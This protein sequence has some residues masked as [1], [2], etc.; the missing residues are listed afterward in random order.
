MRDFTRIKRIMGKLEEV[1]AHNPD[2]RLTQLLIYTGVAADS[3][4]WPMEDEWAEACIDKFG[5]KV[6]K[7]KK[8]GRL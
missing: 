8:E 1:W 3:A 2:M 6:A 5:K 4:L 7:A